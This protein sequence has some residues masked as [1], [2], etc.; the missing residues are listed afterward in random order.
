MSLH[1]RSWQQLGFRL[2]TQPDLAMLPFDQR[3]VL[4]ATRWRPAERPLL[5][6]CTGH[7]SACRQSCLDGSPIRPPGMIDTIDTEVFEHGS[8]SR[9]GLMPRKITCGFQHIDPT[10]AMPVLATSDLCDANE[11]RIELGTLRILPPGMMI[12]GQC[13]HFYGK[14]T[15]LQV[16]ED[17]SLVR[18]LLEKPGDGRVLV[19]DGGGSR[20]VALLGGNLAKLAAENGWRG[21]V[22]HG[23]VR[24]AEEIDTCPI[25]V[26]AWSLSPLRSKKQGL[27]RPHVELDIMGVK[28]KPGD[29]C[30]AD[31]DGI[32]VSELPLHE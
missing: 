23:A 18:A 32:L 28:V 30:Y 22:I 29:W 11:D 21:I 16:L 7:E 2:Q 5:A 26:R 27:G 8:R 31:R 6:C 24:D 12:L 20:R 25:G 17:N 14:V 15:T 19:V 10:C 9:A 4:V 13:L 3:L 1:N